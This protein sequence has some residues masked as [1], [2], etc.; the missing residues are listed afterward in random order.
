MKNLLLLIFTLVLISCIR[1]DNSNM[2]E[3]PNNNSKQIIEQSEY[4]SDSDKQALEES[5]ATVIGGEG[6]TFEKNDNGELE[7]SFDI[8][9]IERISKQL[10]EQLKRTETKFKYDT[11]EEKANAIESAKLN[12]KLFEGTF[13]CTT[14]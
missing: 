13:C 6:V 3:A 2:V 4:A 10:N 14:H 1:H 12:L 7:M 9:S 5:G 8:N 11:P